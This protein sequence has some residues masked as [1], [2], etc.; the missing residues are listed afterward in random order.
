VLLSQTTLDGIAQGTITVVFRRWPTPRVK[1]GSTFK[2][3]IGVVA[4]DTVDKA[5]VLKLADADA[6][7]AGY[8]SKA[9][10]LNELAKYPD[11]QLYRIA[12]RLAGADP[13]IALRADATLSAADADR[14]ER[15]LAAM[16]ARSKDGPWALPILRLIGKRP[17][18]LAARLAASLG[19]EV[20]LFKPRVRRLKELGLTESL[21]VGY[22][23]SPRGRA[24]RRGAGLTGRVP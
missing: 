2:T 22:R 16:G 3:P 24:Y 23:L 6:R 10:L 11:G 14:L 7:A 9:A 5:S 8:P 19:M 15:Q 1:P 18:V 12:V 4:A 20:T 21:E 17:G 13:R